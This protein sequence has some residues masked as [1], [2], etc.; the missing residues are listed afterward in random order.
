MIMDEDAVVVE[1]ENAVRDRGVPIRFLSLQTKG[2]NEAGKLE[3]EPAQV[4]LRVELTLA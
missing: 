4:S 1:S 3:T 2:N